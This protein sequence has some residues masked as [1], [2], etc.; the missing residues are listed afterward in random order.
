M[1]ALNLIRW[2]NLIVIAITQ[3]L[4]KYALLEPFGA[5]T[6]LN[7]LGASLLILA[8]LCI[9]AAGNVINDIYDVETDLIN[10]PDRIVIGKH[11]SEKTAF[12]TFIILNCTG[13]GFGFFLAQYIGKS[14]F[15]SIFIMSSVLL[16]V[17]AAYAKGIMLLGNIIISLLVALSVLIVGVFE[18][19]PNLNET[20]RN[21]RLVF[22]NTILYY[23]IFAFVINLLREIAKTIE[24]VAGDRKAKLYTLPVVMG[25]TGSKILLFVC[26]IAAIALIL[27][28]CVSKLYNYQIILIYFLIFIIAPL[29]Y[30][31]IKCFSATHKSDFNH[32]SSVFKIVMVFGMLSLLLYRLTM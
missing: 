1:H 18:L 31:C 28:Y 26:N 23:A 6:A 15:F 21:I 12:N 5:L 24:D 30:T 2:K 3:L 11:I 19:A 13:V 17:Y 32:L 7:G 8:T 4:I 29:I 22:F 14:P 10:K 27:F 9:A 25:I 20:N 16:Y